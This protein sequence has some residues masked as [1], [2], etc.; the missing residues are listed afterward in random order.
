MRLRRF[1]G[2]MAM[3]YPTTEWF[4]LVSP[5][6]HETVVDA[7]MGVGEDLTEHGEAVEELLRRHAQV[8]LESHD[9]GIPYAVPVL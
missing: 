4:S 8:C 2:S 5:Y 9:P 1:A 6:A 3:M 7:E